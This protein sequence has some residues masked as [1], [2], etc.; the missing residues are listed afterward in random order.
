MIDFKVLISLLLCFA[1]AGFIA[2]QDRPSDAP[3]E[4]DRKSLT[5]LSGLNGAYYFKENSC[6]YYSV[7]YN[8]NEDY[9]Y[10][11]TNST[12]L[13]NR[14]GLEMN[15]G[16]RWYG[17]GSISHRLAYDPKKNM[18]TLKGNLSHRGKIGS[19]QFL[20]ELSVEYIHHFN[21]DFF[22]TDK[23]IQ[24]GIGAALFKD[25]NVAGRPLG[26][27]LSYKILL[28]TKL[29]Y[30]IYK[31]RNIDFTK[32]RFDVFYGLSKS[33]YVGIYAMRETEYYYPLGT[34]DAQG[35]N[36]YFKR[37]DISPVVG[38]N[39]NFILHPEN[40]ERYIPGLPFR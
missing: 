6:L 40:M 7:D 23:D 33:V 25:F 18:A 19:V 34:S 39:L 38:V 36:I 2:A 20:K 27:L 21:Y 29:Q 28:N 14:V 32:F 26:L 15:I 30:D 10:R 1:S 31:Y 16:G 13:Y 8:F 11:I 5:V 4:K 9:R 37:N 22:D 35:N 17:G 24:L 12:R 3:I